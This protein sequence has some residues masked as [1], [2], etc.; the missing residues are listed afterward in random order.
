MVIIKRTG[1]AD[2][3]LVVRGR[4]HLRGVLKTSNERL[5]HVGDV[6]F[7]WRADFIVGVAAMLPASA[8][9][10]DKKELNNTKVELKKALT[11]HCG[12]SFEEATRLA[13]DPIYLGEYF[14]E[15]RPA[16]YEDS[17]EIPDSDS[18]SDDQESTGSPVLVQRPSRR[19]LR[20]FLEKRAKGEPIDFAQDIDDDT[21]LLGS[22]PT[23]KASD[24]DSELDLP[25]KERG[26]RGRGLAAAGGEA[27]G[28]P[29]GN[30]VGAGSRAAGRGGAGLGAGVQERCVPGAGSCVGATGRGRGRGRG[31]GGATAQVWVQARTQCHAHQSLP[32]RTIMPRRVRGRCDPPKTSC[33]LTSLPGTGPGPAGGRDGARVRTRLPPLLL[34]PR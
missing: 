26:G 34:S 1:Q 13:A 6:P 3:I 25:L 17:D 11:S 7:T 21:P 14:N 32:E 22:I 23:S 24:S 28:A 5:Y 15:A 4:N 8:L 2:K 19:P 9:L 33:P 10:S 30:C 12:M 20:K 31:R 18:H 27:N 16:T 29:T